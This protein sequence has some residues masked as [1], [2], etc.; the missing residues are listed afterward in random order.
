M[1]DPCVWKEE[2][3]DTGLNSD[4][5]FGRGGMDAPFITKVR[6]NKLVNNPR[7]PLLD[8]N[9]CIVQAPFCRTVLSYCAGFNSVVLGTSRRLVHYFPFPNHAYMTMTDGLA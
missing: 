6:K 9:R 3:Q 7:M 5:R 1:L 2:D 8:M 4:I